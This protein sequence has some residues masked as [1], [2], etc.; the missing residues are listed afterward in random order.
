MPLYGT[1]ETA[2][3]ACSRKGMCHILRNVETSDG[4][5]YTTGATTS[6]FH[7]HL[8]AEEFLPS[9]ANIDAAPRGL[10]PKNYSKC[11]SRLQHMLPKFWFHAD[12]CHCCL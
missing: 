11:I 1:S 12:A 7:E 2:D 10:R 5:F 6:V 8:S 9:E 4:A 3:H